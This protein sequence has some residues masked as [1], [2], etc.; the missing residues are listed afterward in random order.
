MLMSTLP[1]APMS[2]VKRGLCCRMIILSQSQSL[3]KEDMSVCRVGVENAF[4]TV[5]DLWGFLDHKRNLKLMQNPVVYLSLVGV[6]KTKAH[7]CK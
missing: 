5:C 3:E 2:H 7:T 4:G 6:L 1:N